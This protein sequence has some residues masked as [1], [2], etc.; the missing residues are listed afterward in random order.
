[1]PGYSGIHTVLPMP[2][3]DET[4]HAAEYFG[5]S[6]ETTPDGLSVAESPAHIG[7]F[8]YTF[9]GEDVPADILEVPA[10][11]RAG[12]GPDPTLHADR[13]LKRNDIHGPVQAFRGSCRN[14]LPI[15]QN[16]DR[17]ASDHAPRS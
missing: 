16:T 2:K 13:S 7:Q 4:L 11:G 12:G 1:M 5:F 14:R 15:E 9:F 8:L 17:P 10:V 3:I 6:R